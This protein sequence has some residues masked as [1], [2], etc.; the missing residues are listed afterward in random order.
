MPRHA[1]GSELA[2]S[3]V[4]NA[5]GLGALALARSMPAKNAAYSL[6]TPPTQLAKGNYFSLS[7]KA[8]FSRLIYPLPED[9]GLGVHLTLDLGGRGRF[10]PD[11]QWIPAN[12]TIDWRVDPARASGF[13]ASIRRWWPALP[14]GALQPDYSGVRPKLGG[15][16]APSQDF[17][18]DGPGAHGWP[19]L[20]QLLGIESPGLTSC[21]AIADEVTRLL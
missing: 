18:I 8:P 3:V 21:L 16:E 15:P 20:V 5:A 9:G 10:G 19:G 13:E 17:R 7:G 2:A 1:A 11:V 6:P 12:E 14:Q 4:V